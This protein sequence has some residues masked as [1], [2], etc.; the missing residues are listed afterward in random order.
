MMAFELIGMLSRL[1][2]AH[3]TEW[4]I[5]DYDRL[6]KRFVKNPGPE[7]QVFKNG[8]KSIWRHVDFTDVPVCG[9]ADCSMAGDIYKQ[10]ARHLD[11]LPGGFPPT[12]SGVEIRILKRLF[13][14]E[15][16]RLAC[17]LTLLAETVPVIALRSGLTVARAGEL[18]DE[19]AHKGLVFKS[20]PPPRYMAAQFVVG[21]WEY[22]VGRLD[23]GL[24]DDMEEYLPQLFDG[25][26]WRASPQMRTIPVGRS[27]DA[28]LKI[29]PHETASALLEKKDSFVVTPCICR[30]EQHM[31]GSGCD[32]PLEACISFGAA[33]SYYIET[34]AGRRASRTEVIEI[35]KRADKSGLVLQA[36]NGRDIS[37]ICCCCGCC[38]GVL[39]NLKRYPRPADMVAAPFT[40]RLDP[41]LCNGC[42]VCETR[43]QLLALT[44]AGDQAQLDAGRCI[45]CGLCVSTCAAG[46]LTLAR[47]PAAQQPRVPLNT[48][49][50]MLRLA[51]KRKV[52][53]PGSLIRMVLTS[54]KDRLRVK[55][56]TNI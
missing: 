55:Q 27:I 46:A 33:D 5:P 22:Q 23:P 2:V 43:C 39:R 54:Q 9:T 41:A 48:A 4:I 13:S 32:R 53:G 11:R 38:C 26:A 14:P 6:H 7:D 24:V 1:I 45:G 50:S 3:K 44:I 20:S 40:T 21:I 37:W 10:L 25:G 30:K 31:Q 36:S 28:G 19:M 49:T 47:K 52:T 51:W 17:H 29:L 18:L 15:E 8:I 34:G 12:Q 42:G 35:L 16:A 56:R